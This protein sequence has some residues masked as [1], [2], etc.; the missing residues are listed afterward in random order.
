[1]YPRLSRVPRIYHFDG[2]EVD[3]QIGSLTRDRERIQVQELPFQLLVALL[4][5]PGELVSREE[6]QERLWPPG[7]HLDFETSLAT[8]VRKLRQALGDTAREPRYIETLPG[9][10]YRFLQDVVRSEHPPIPQLGA[11]PEAMPTCQ[12][13]DGRVVPFRGARAPVSAKISTGFRRS[14]IRWSMAGLALLLSA[15]VLTLGRSWPGR[16][17]ATLQRPLP[18]LLAMPTKVLGPPDSAFLS[19]AIPDTLSTLLAGVEGLDTKVPPTSAQVDR[20]QGDVARIAEAYKADYLILTTVTTRGDRLL[21]NVKLAEGSTQKI[22]WTSHYEATRDTYNLLLSDAARALVAVLNPAST[23]ARTVG[24]PAF[25]SQA[26]LALREG[27]FFQRKFEISKSLPDFDLALS[28]FRRAQLLEPSSALL[29]A[30]IAFLFEQLH[31]HT[32]EPKALV[33]G[34]RWVARALELDPRCGKAWWV[35]NWIESD[36]PKADRAAMVAFTLKATRYAPNEAST[37]VN[38]ACEAPTRGFAVTAGKRAI[39][40]DPLDPAGYFVTALSLAG[41]GRAEEGL[42]FAERGL[43]LGASIEEL[44]WAKFL[45]LFHAGRFEEAKQVIP[46]ARA[47][48]TVRLMHLIMSGN[49]AG[50]R[51]LVRTLVGKWCHEDSGSDDWANRTAFCGPLFLRLGMN[52]EMLWLLEKGT[53]AGS[54]PGIDWFVDNPDSMKLRGDPRYVKAFTISRKHA[55]LF[56]QQSDTAKARGEFPRQMEQPLGEL[57]ALM[58]KALTP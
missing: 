3:E 23:G 7:I 33:E 55:L 19:D 15:G 8:A 52:E 28:A 1:M 6:L 53:E 2:F 46:E 47:S 24:Q 30:E 45:C 21:L 42:S 14:L 41:P 22:R 37:Y 56:L 9:R 57:R 5:R 27:K 48:E 18:V 10:G 25:S 44:T 35:R 54:P 26:E 16:S 20:I 34:E 17:T 43:R 40:L 12:D 29:A 13:G 58:D 39:E 36:R 4:E 51:D 49:I 32:R 50:G 11:R 31:R 38:L